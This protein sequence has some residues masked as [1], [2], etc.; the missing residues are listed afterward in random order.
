MF[1]VDH[2]AFPVVTLSLFGKRGILY[3]FGSFPNKI[4]EDV[5]AA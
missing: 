1:N 4:I 5:V 2:V 3:N